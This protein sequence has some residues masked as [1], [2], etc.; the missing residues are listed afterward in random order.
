VGGLRGGEWASGCVGGCVARRSV[1]S[2]SC[3]CE[4]RVEV[5]VSASIASA[6]ASCGCE[7]RVRVRVAGASCEC[8]LRVGVRVA[9]ASCELRVRVQ[10]DLRVR[11]QSEL[12]VR[13]QSELRVASACARAGEDAKA[14]F[15]PSKAC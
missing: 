5:C 7:L 13:V 6:G 1:A 8:E 11:V 2:A 3:G 15:V 10:S 12:R 4:L 9:C 14:G